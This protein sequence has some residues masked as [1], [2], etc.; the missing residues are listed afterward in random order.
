MTV[1]PNKSVHFPLFRTASSQTLGPVV[2]FS[3]TISITERFWTCKARN[4]NGV[5]LVHCLCNVFW[6]C[7]HCA[8][9]SQTVTHSFLHVAGLMNPLQALKLNFNPQVM[10]GIT[11]D[12]NGNISKV[13]VFQYILRCRVEDS[14]RTDDRV[15]EWTKVAAEDVLAYTPSD[16]KVYPY[17]FGIQQEET[18]SNI[19]GDLR[20]LIFG[21]FLLFL[22]A[23][24]VFSSNSQIHSRVAMVLV[25]LIAIA[26]AIIS[27]F[28]VASMIGQKWNQVV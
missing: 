15:K 1:A 25:S 14:L 6:C 18:S 19:Q 3:I 11:Y 28:G 10:G 4:G 9:V 26:L 13:E 16:S 5:L 17:S 27:S 8:N 24:F 20:K 23:G 21:F 2:A 12:S 22:Y 7:L